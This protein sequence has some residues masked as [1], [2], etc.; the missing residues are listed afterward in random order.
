MIIHNL[1]PFLLVLI[2]EQ[3]RDVDKGAGVDLK[4]NTTRNGFLVEFR[5]KIAEKVENRTG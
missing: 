3:G 5:I 2:T 4:C 1:P